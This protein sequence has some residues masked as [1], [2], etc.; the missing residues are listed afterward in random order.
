MDKWFILSIILAIFASVV[1]IFS[2]RK[3]IQ[4]IESSSNISVDDF[5]ILE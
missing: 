4:E 3:G 2:R 1:V 5:E